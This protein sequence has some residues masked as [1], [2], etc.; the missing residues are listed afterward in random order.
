MNT[1]WDCCP[2][3]AMLELKIPHFYEKM[4]IGCVLCPTVLQIK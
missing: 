1:E 3:E 4:Y 2:L